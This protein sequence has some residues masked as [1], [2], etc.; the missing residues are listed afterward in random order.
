[1]RQYRTHYRL[2]GI[3]FGVFFIPI[4]LLWM[5]GE[6]WTGAGFERIGRDVWRVTSGYLAGAWAIQAIMVVCSD[7]LTDT[8]DQAPDYDDKPPRP[9]G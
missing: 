4:M 1:M 3:V 7:R 8:P 9:T 2:W 5:A 6:E